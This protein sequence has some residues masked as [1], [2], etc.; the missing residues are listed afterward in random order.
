M[1]RIEGIDMEVI[2]QLKVELINKIE[3]LDDKI[4][5]LNVYTERIFGGMTEEII[6]IGQ[7]G[8]LK[9]NGKDE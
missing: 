8:S 1:S 4:N 5:N 9:T 2:H 6:K 3:S 7:G